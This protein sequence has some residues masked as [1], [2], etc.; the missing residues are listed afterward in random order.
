MYPEVVEFLRQVRQAGNGDC[1]V[2]NDALLQETSV[3]DLAIAGKRLKDGDD[4]QSNLDPA[5]VQRDNEVHNARAELGATPTLFD[6][7]RRP[8]AT[9]EANEQA[10]P[11]E[12]R[13]KDGRNAALGNE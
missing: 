2:V 13:M 5:L 12:R 10:A 7:G 9:F 4:G 3:Y 1:L 6:Q 11:R 8:H